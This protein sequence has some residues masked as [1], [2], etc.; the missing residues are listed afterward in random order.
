MV[1]LR[2]HPP[3][4]YH[5]HLRSDLHPKVQGTD[6]PTLDLLS[7]AA[8]LRDVIKAEHEQAERKRQ[9]MLTLER[10][11]E[12]CHENR[13]GVTL[14]QQMEVALEAGVH[15][16]AKCVRQG[17]KLLGEI[18]QAEEFRKRLSQA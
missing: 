2:A 9:A 13:D 3:R 10:V 8:T 7:R 5:T 17:K 12:K 1:F 4:Y 6:K 11:I 16:K 18:K 14:S 15:P